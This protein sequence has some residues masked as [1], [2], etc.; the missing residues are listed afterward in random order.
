MKKLLFALLGASTLCLTHT[1]KAD[2]LSGNGQA[3][4][5]YLQTLQHNPNGLLIFLQ[6]MPKGA[7]LHNHR[8]GAAYAENMI[9]AAATTDMCLDPKTFTVTTDKNCPDNLKLKNLPQNSDLYNQT[10]NAWSLRDF[11]PSAQESMLDH[12]FSVFLK[13]GDLSDAV[14]SQNLT[15]IVN[16]AG[17]Q[18]EIYLETMITAERNNAIALA[19]NI[20]WNNNFDTMRQQLANDN[21]NTIVSNIQTELNDNE[22]YLKKTLQCGTTQAQPG[23]NVTVRYQ[24]IPL[25]V[26]SPTA[27]FAQLM[28]GFELAN[29]DPRVVA[30]NMVGPEDNYIS[31]RD[32]HLQMQ[33]IDY[34]HKLYP[35]VHIDLHAGELEF[36]SVTP[37]NMTFHIRDA[38]E[39]AHAQRIGH[40]TDIAYENN[41][42]QLLQEMATKQIAVEICLTS[43]ADILNVKGK[44]SPL[45]LYLK[46][47]V[48]VVLATD[49]EGVL[50]TDLTHEFQRAILTY[51]F[52]YPTMKAFVRNSLTYNFMPGQSLWSDPKEFSPV[53]ACARDTLGGTKPSPNCATFLKQNPKAQLQWQLEQQFT[54]FEKQTAAIYRAQ[55]ALE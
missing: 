24:Y 39:T 28:V 41:P 33:M 53:A 3:T 49:D 34:F 27:V 7:D 50:R 9:A 15:E 46:S 45:T 22:A 12:F 23:C 11:V 32:Y 16:R 47:G 51:Q 13:Y 31:L 20:T 25:R 43:N 55:T 6:N 26:V 19:N 42:N 30:I 2:T 36:G 37:A 40:G 10:I 17:N 8:S 52:D 29:K 44:L 1:V 48:P 54:A 38:I 5:S 14:R 35:N 18:H 21:I 4:A